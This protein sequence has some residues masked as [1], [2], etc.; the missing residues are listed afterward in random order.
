[1]SDEVWRPVVRESLNRYLNELL[2]DEERILL[3]DWI[4]RLRRQLRLA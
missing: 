2:D 1:M 3:L 4:R